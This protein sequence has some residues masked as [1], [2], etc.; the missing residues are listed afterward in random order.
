MF[1]GVGDPRT[2]LAE[3]V[4]GI[5]ASYDEHGNINH[6]DGSNLPALAEV[7]ALLNDLLSLLFPGFFGRD[8]VDELSSR[9]FVGERCA[10]SLRRLEEMIARAVDCGSRSPEEKELV[11]REQ[12]IALLETMP[13]IRRRLAADVQ[14]AMAG[15]PAARSAPEVVSSY[16]G[17][18]AI[19]VYRL[20]HQLWISGVPLLPRMMS[21]IIHSRTGI[22]I[23]PGADIGEGFFIDHGT[24]VVIGETS[25][26]GNGVKLYQGVTLGALSTRGDV[27]A[28]GGQRHP[29]LEDEV[30]VYAGATILGGRTVIGRG[31]TVGGNVWLTQSVA[32]GTTVLLAEPSLRF[33][34][35]GE[36]DGSA[37]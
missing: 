11:A 31:S 14:A 13:E 12:A 10:R 29:T 15:D 25:K 33:V 5:L 7:N 3:V 22:D 32:P 20:A 28:Q 8:I 30:T 16:P 9:W 23:H 35:A 6:L 21:E 24:G 34:N 19:A 17:V 18:T 4:E 1:R 37:K 26:I 27:A 2:K 36:R